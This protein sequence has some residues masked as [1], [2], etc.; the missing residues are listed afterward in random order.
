MPRL[1]RLTSHGH[2]EL[3]I[4]PLP[5]YQTMIPKRNLP[6]SLVSLFGWN[7]E[8]SLIH[9]PLV[10]F[11]VNE[12]ASKN[13][14]HGFDLCYNVC[15]YST[16]IHSYLHIPSWLIMYCT[17]HIARQKLFHQS[18]QNCYNGICNMNCCWPV[19]RSMIHTYIQENGN[20]N[21]NGNENAWV[22]LILICR[23]RAQ[24][25]EGLKIERRFVIFYILLFSS[26]SNHAAWNKLSLPFFFF[27]F[28]L[29]AVEESLAFNLS[30]L[31]A[32]L[33]RV[34]MCYYILLCT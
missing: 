19:V 26:V 24:R 28:S 5:D 3:A 14:K 7:L 18:S 10:L 11:R 27:F 20:G 2:V 9:N 23:C 33:G 34:H 30:T 12:W 13:L 16:Y 15:M 22:R 6:K 25:R 32:L 21:G 4:A 29:R 8:S 17:I 1:L 31:I